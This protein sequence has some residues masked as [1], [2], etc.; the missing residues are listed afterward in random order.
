MGAYVVSKE[1]QAKVDRLFPKGKSGEIIKALEGGKVIN[2]GPHKLKASYVEEGDKAGEKTSP[3]ATPPA[4][5]PSGT[6]KTSGKQDGKE[7]GK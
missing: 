6:G 2:V 5:N 3:P 1:L 4:D 7:A